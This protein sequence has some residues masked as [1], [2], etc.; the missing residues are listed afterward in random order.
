[1]KSEIYH[2]PFG[3]AVRRKTTSIITAKTAHPGPRTCRARH[4]TRLARSINR[5]IYALRRVPCC[6]RSETKGSH[7][8]QTTD[9]SAGAFLLFDIDLKSL[10][11]GTATRR[12]CRHFRQFG[13]PL[14][15]G[16]TRRVSTI[17]ACTTNS[18]CP[19]CLDALD[20][21]QEMANGPTLVQTSRISLR[22]VGIHISPSS[23]GSES[24]ATSDLR[25]AP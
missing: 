1:M 10:Y 24:E 2:P 17:L 22:L 12:G 4:H 16:S 11:G 7:S 8:R 19:E 20:F 14:D 3:S 21:R 23:A 15:V 5:D 6:G 13:R 18:R 9:A 25:R